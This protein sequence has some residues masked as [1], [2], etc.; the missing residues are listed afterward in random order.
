LGL[1]VAIE[2][3]LD[4]VLAPLA[5]GAEAGAPSGETEHLAQV[6]AD[7]GNA[8]AGMEGAVM[9]FN[10]AL[11]SFAGTTRDFREF[12]LHLRDN[13][14]RMSLS[15]ADVSETVKHHVHALREP[16]R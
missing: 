1:M 7:F 12:N 6:V 13:V 8:V 3:H 9:Q 15:F 10:T 14:Q 11:Q 4:Q 16:R 2:A 5:G